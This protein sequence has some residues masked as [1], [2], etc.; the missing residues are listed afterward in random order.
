MKH[1]GET[2]SLG[3]IDRQKG[4]GMRKKQNSSNCMKML[5]RSL[6]EQRETGEV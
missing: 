5:N 3:Q 6:V 1:P 2:A 4:R